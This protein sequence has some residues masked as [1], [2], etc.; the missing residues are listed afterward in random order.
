M[1]SWKKTWKVTADRL[2]KR[3]K[4]WKKAVKDVPIMYDFLKEN[5]YQ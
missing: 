2:D 3:K 5:Y 4:E 1:D